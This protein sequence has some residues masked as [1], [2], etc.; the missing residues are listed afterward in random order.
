MHGWM[1]T[2]ETKARGELHQQSGPGRNRSYNRMSLQ[3]MKAKPNK[4]EAVTENAFAGL[5]A[6]GLPAG[7]APAPAP[8][9]AAP[10]SRWKMGKV[11]LQRKTA[12]RGG[13]TVTVIKDFA[14]HLP[15]SVIEMIAK[16]VRSACGCGG[17][18]KDRRIEIQGDQPAKIR[19]VLEAEGFEV[20]GIK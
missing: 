16:R 2:E 7:N 13:K 9:S 1:W 19:A 8:A 6:E 15:L 3:A 10:Q 14:S 4:T 20:G 11:I 17:T 5:K 12:H 18:V